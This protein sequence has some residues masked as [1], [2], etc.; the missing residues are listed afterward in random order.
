MSILLTDDN[1][2]RMA[3]VPNSTWAMQVAALTASR[4]RAI[5]IG[6]ETSHR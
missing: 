5:P 4:R 2:L 3:S 6:N 1:T